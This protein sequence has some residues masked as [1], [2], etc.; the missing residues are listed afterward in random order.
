MEVN[1]MEI[2]Y[3]PIFLIWNN[4]ELP[5]ELKESIIF[6][7]DKKVDKMD[8]INYRGIFFVY[9][10]TMLS[11]KHL[12]RTFP[13]TIGIIGVRVYQCDFRRNR[14]IVEQIS[15]QNFANT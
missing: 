14:S 8:C 2:L 10:N 13:Y 5:Q 1:Y 9:L 15:I 7:V 12:V 3:R 11:N 4:E 6:P